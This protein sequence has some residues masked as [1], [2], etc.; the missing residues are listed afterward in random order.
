MKEKIN[1][2][3]YA[4]YFIK[5]QKEFESKENN[6]KDP[7][8]DENRK[9]GE[10]ES[11]LYHIIR[12]DIINDFISH[13]T[14][15]EI[16]LKTTVSYSIY[17][18][19]SFLLYEKPNLIE[20][21]AFFGSIQIFNYLFKN[22]VKLT[23]S[24]WL[25]AIHGKNPKIIKILVDNKIIPEDKSYKKFLREAIKCHHNEIVVY[26]KSNLIHNQIDVDEFIG[27][28]SIEY[29]NY[30]LLP[31]DKLY[32]RNNFYKFCK[33]D[34][35]YFAEGFLMNREID[36]NFKTCDIINDESYILTPLIIAIKNNSL[37]IAELLLKQPGIDVNFQ[38]TC[39]NLRDSSERTFNA[40]NLA[41]ICN[42][43]K[44]IELLLNTENINVN[45]ILMSKEKHQNNTIEIIEFSPLFE[46]LNYYKNVQ[47]LKILL[48][49]PDIDVNVKIKYTTYDTKD[50][51]KIVKYHNS[52]ILCSAIKNADLDIIKLFLEHPKIDVHAI[53]FGED[54]T[55]KYKIKFTP[56]VI[57]F[58]TNNLEI[59]KILLSHPEIDVNKCVKSENDGKISQFT[60]F[61]F[62]IFNNEVI[63]TT[64]LQVI[65]LL[66]SHKNTDVNYD[67][68][69]DCGTPLIYAIEHQKKDLITLLLS[70]PN[71]DVNA[72]SI[73]NSKDG[74]ST[75]KNPLSVALENNYKETA[76]L[77]LNHPKIDVNIKI[78][79]KK[80]DFSQIKHRALLHIAIHKENI[81]V[82][83]AIL[84][85]PNVDLN[86]KSSERTV[87]NNDTI[88]KEKTTMHEAI[89]SNNLEIIQLLLSK[90]EIDINMK[91]TKTVFENN[92][93][94][95]EEQTP[96]RFAVNME[97]V[98][99]I[100]LLLSSLR[101]SG[102]MTDD[103]NDLMKTTDDNKIKSIIYENINMQS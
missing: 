81:D 34:Y 6:Q 16:S 69:E 50:S 86:I 29:Y 95:I 27:S 51:I 33:Y 31:N 10:N 40:L 13:V 36:I 8:F 84:D 26:I 94:F 89:I 103:L 21:A 55:T 99:I 70:N 98:E 92:N 65:S 44:M 73:I 66:L 88:E 74:Y 78:L 19:N 63:E 1:L 25:Y 77:L 96:L 93:F 58:V 11:K 72:K 87:K 80:I 52:P 60:P 23:P 42:N 2:L 43:P 20:Y 67:S 41:I 30:L 101:K 12:N 68:K 47:I 28:E 79:H 91:S 61:F 100:Q 9:T 57:A 45:S 14:H 54:I 64:K 59:I 71:I 56:L 49:H 82:I 48:S 62:E 18:T 32:N 24:I 4:K 102:K 15:N 39:Y 35:F 75:E 7:N 3:H 83:K 90:P 76:L 17:E 37:S 38:S 97:N 22:K 46:V 53:E 5:E 85:N